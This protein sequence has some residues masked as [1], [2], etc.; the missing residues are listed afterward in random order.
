MQFNMTIWTRDW[1]HF[2]QSEVGR[3]G[4][5]GLTDDELVEYLRWMACNRPGKYVKVMTAFAKTQENPKTA[6]VM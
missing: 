5:E 1:E 2:N 4:A 3:N 6:V